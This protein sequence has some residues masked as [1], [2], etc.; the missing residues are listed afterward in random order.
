MYR[1][2][3]AAPSCVWYSAC[4]SPVVSQSRRAVSGAGH[5][6]QPAGANCDAVAACP[7]AASRRAWQLLQ[8]TTLQGVAC[9]G[10]WEAAGWG[11]SCAEHTAPM[12]TC[13]QLSRPE[14]AASSSSAARRPPPRQGRSRASSCAGEGVMSSI[15][16]L[17]HCGCHLAVAAA[18]D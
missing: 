9:C 2:V 3:C 18:G 7:Q 4:T 15:E 1:S 12:S 11:S 14:A 13:S 16:A 10:C 8:G 17:V 6:Q 5:R